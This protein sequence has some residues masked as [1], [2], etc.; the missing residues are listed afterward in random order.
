MGVNVLIERFKVGEQ[1]DQV[2]QDNGCALLR[3]VRSGMMVS[4]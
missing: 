1:L 2:R 3:E 4:F